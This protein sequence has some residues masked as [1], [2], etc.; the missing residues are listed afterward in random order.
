VSAVLLRKAILGVAATVETTYRRLE[1]IESGGEFQQQRGLRHA[2]ELILTL[3][4]LVDGKSLHDAF[5]APG[6]WGYD[7]PMGQALYAHYSQPS[8]AEVS[9]AR[10][11]NA[12]ARLRDVA[13]DVR[14]LFDEAAEPIVSFIAAHESAGAR[15]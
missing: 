10:A 1:D 8:T 2:Y 14:E 15:A 12:L 5:G 4:R 13:D 7:T 11:R 9:A 3:G 6:D